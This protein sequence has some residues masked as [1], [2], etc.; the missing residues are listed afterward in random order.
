MK[1]LVSYLLLLSLLAGILVSCSPADGFPFLS[2]PAKTDALAWNGTESDTSWYTKNTASASFSLSDGADLRGFIKLVYEDG[3]S[4]AGKTLTLTNDIDLGGKP[5]SIP[6]G[7]QYTFSGAFDGNGKKISSF[8]MTCTGGEQ[9]LLGVLGGGGSVKSLTVSGAKITLKATA[10]AENAGI[11]LSKITCEGGKSVAVSGI[12]VDN[13]CKISFFS[14]SKSYT[15]VGAIAGQITGGGNVTVSNC[16]N[17]ASITCYGIMGGIAGCGIDWSGNLTIENC[18]N[19]G[20]LTVYADANEGRCA[21]I[22]GYL[23]ATGGTLT[24]A[25]CDN[26]GKLT[27]TGTKTN[28]GAWMGGIGGYFHGDLK[29]VTVKGCSNTGKIVSANRCTGGILGFVQTAKALTIAGC[30]VDADMEFLYRSTKYPGFGGIIGVINTASG[31]P[32]EIK[33]CRVSGTLTNNDPSDRETFVGGIIGLLRGTHATVTDCEVSLTFQKEGCE[34]DDHFNVVMGGYADGAST[35]DIPTLTSSKSSVTVTGLIYNQKN[36]IPTLDPS[37]QLADRTFVKS[38]G[39]QYRKN[40]DGSY[41]FRFVF[42]VANLQKDDRILG[43]NVNIKALGETVS[44]ASFSRYVSTLYP[45]LLDG[46]GKRTEAYEYGCD[47]FFTL[48]LSNVPGVEVTDT[49]DYI[50]NTLVD[51]KPYFQSHSNDEPRYS[52]MLLDH[53]LTP[54]R[55][56]FGLEDF[57]SRLPDDFDPATG[58]LSAMDVSYSPAHAVDCESYRQL[59]NNDQYVLQKS[60]TCGGNCSWSANGAVAYKL[61][62]SVPYHYYI[63]TSSYESNFGKALDRYEAY[64]TWSFQVPADGYYELCFRIRLSGDQGGRQTRYALVQLDGEAYGEQT[65]FYYNVLTRDGTLRD[66]NTNCDSYLRGFCRYLTAGTHT[67]TFRL[68]YPTGEE[69]KNAS[70]HIRDIYLKAGALPLHADIPLPEGAALYDGNFDNSVT[71]YLDNTSLAVLDSYRE[72]LVT[73][74]Y[75]LQEQTVSEGYRFSAF[76]S[77]NFKEGDNPERFNRFYLYTNDAYMVYVYFAEGARAIRIVVDDLEDYN[78]YLAVHKPAAYETVTTP[79]F[80]MLDI[81]GVN[82]DMPN[83]YVSNGMCLVYRLSDGR[84]VVVDG[85]YWYDEK[86]P[87]GTAADRLYKW[88]AKHAD[89]DGDG[90]YT[91]NHITVAAWVF[92]HNHSDHISVAWK[93]EE[94]YGGKNLTV[95]SYLYNFPSYE[96]A[97]SIY[98]TNLKEAYYSRWYPNMHQLMQDNNNIVVR[99]GMTYYFAD[100]KI[101]ILFTHDDFTPQLYKSYNNSNTVYKITLAGKTFL[102]AGDLEEPGQLQAIKQTGTM[103][104][105]DVLQITHHGYNG[106]LEF[107]QYIVGTENND[108]VTFHT[109]TIVVW[110]L[111]R[112]EYAEILTRL[113]A[114][115]WIAKMFRQEGNLNGDNLYYAAENFEMEIK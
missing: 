86:D 78:K 104:E 15:R 58:V 33:N 82:D 90:D 92:T 41:D 72:Q 18:T 38:I 77:R 6:A 55:H 17:S 24:I 87:T 103:L 4:F 51:I 19:N 13:S 68:P 22:L 106:Q 84:F 37:I 85:G 35:S 16:H 80:A 97:M 83:L 66:N 112:G 101:E 49:G 115:K 110:P 7:T 48:V 65:E 102:V 27:Y 44:S 98:G 111:P 100:C 32:V 47:Y 60:C 23:S 28:G 67:I 46:S 39:T 36:H 113:E 63:D 70:F 88:L 114:N 25:N 14:S 81:G 62:A 89:Y 79:L 74:G 5:W 108:G 10:A 11:L 105:A 21:G 76:D 50:Q 94:K 31:A 8:T 30:M 34:D 43:L 69:K 1:K 56:T 99:T 93:M 42:G 40:S 64:H 9:S 45:F 95:E 71:Y 91:N 2:F 12:T 96:Y 57:S 59:G 54:T 107:Y 61:N 52:G 26:S 20:D 73:A 109:D 29:S 75:T 3:V 53:S